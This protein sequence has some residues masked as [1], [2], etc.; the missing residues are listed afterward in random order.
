MNDRRIHDLPGDIR[1]HIL[2][3]IIKEAEE[4]INRQELKIAEVLP[5]LN[6]LIGTTVEQ[7][8]WQDHICMDWKPPRLMEFEIVPL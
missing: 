3:E 4:E 2:R 1:V 7:V 8:R 5:T 6:S